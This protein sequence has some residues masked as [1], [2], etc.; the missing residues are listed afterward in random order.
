MKPTVAIRL[1]RLL[2]AGALALVVAHAGICGAGELGMTAP[3]LTISKWIKGGPVDLSAKKDF[4]YVISFWVSWHPTGRMGLAGL[5]DLQNKYAAQG[6]QIIGIS[7]ESEETVERFV[8]LMGGKMD[9]T[10]AVDADGATSL[11]YMEALG[12][13]GVPHTFIL[14]KQRRIV[15]HGQETLEMEPVI[16]GILDGTWDFEKARKAE[17]ARATLNLYFSGVAQGRDSEHLKALGMGVVLSVEGDA[18]FLNE[19]AWIILTHEAIRTRHLD[20]AM[21][22]AELAYKAC[23]GKDAAIVDTYAR[24]F[25]DTGDKKKAIEYQKKAVELEKD[26]A[27]RAELQRTLDRYLAGK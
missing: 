23:E 3:K 26:P 24:A 10:V 2:R 18:G 17:A 19:I 1:S 7:D 11:A 5:T 12:V 13:R 20:I 8:K 14:D 15:W 4:V 21:K 22:A 6:V 9:F 16:K 25:Y 27:Q